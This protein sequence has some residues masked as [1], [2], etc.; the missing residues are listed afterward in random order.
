MGDA[1]ERDFVTYETDGTIAI[2]G[3]N[4]PHKRNAV[5]DWFIQVLRYFINK[6][7]SHCFVKTLLIVICTKYSCNIIRIGRLIKAGVFKRH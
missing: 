2:I 5:S 3:L 6:L 7:Y 1:E 4:R